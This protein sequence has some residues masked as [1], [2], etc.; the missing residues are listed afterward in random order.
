MALFKSMAEVKNYVSAFN[1]NME[2]ASLLPHIEQAEIRYILPLLGT[3]QHGS[4]H[5]AYQSSTMTAEHI[6]LLR[7]VQRSLA[8]YALYE[9][10]PY[11]AAMVGDMG[12]TEAQAS[13][14]TAT[15]A[16]QWIAKD[17]RASAIQSADNHADWLLQFLEA[18]AT[19][20]TDWAG[21]SAATAAKALFLNT[22][23]EFD[24]LLGIGGSRR[25]FLALCP[26]IRLAEQEYILPALGESLFNDLKAKIADRDTPLSADDAKLLALVQRALAYLSMYKAMPFLAIQVSA[27]GITTSSAN[28]GQDSRSPADRKAYETLVTHTDQTGQSL[29][30]SLR[31]FLDLNCTKYPLYESDET[32]NAQPFYTLPD[33]RGQRSFMV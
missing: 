31:Q 20:Y 14:G 17:L 28:D 18:N 2:F 22:T 12:V 10:V 16:R 24:N 13:E 8:Y 5:A 9:A 19:T 15:P 25:T 23:A 32:R 1:R 30:R 7:H 26:Y 33:N 29:L 4:L 6:N 3:A 11:L 21:S 27:L